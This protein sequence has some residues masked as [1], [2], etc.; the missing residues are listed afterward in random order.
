MSKPHARERERDR[1]EPREPGE[2]EA[3]REHLTHDPAA[4][5][6][7]RAPDRN[8]LLAPRAAHEQQV[9]DVRADD[10]EHDA[11]G[12]DEH[13]QRRRNGRRQLVERA[14]D[15]E[16]RLG[17]GLGLDAAQLQPERVGL[18]ARR[19][20]RNA[21]GELRLRGQE[22]DLARCRS[23]ARTNA[24]QNASSPNAGGMTP[25]TV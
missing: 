23:A 11:D 7:E 21:G 6:T 16:A 14:H 17:T 3:L 13:S 12:D 10:R 5:R 9:R 18:R 8:L 15:L 2:H 24:V 22:N 4:R 1:G 25:T 20:E 19:L